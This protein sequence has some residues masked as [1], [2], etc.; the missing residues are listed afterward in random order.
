[1]DRVA[2]KISIR[3]VRTIRRGINFADFHI[4]MLDVSET[5]RHGWMDDE[6]LF[7]FYSW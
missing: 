6:F 1:M 5:T 3:V 2:K 7:Q 4:P